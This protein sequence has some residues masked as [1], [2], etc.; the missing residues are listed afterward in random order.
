[1]M[2]LSYADVVI[3]GRP[4]SFTQSLPMTMALATP[5]PKRKVLQSFC[6]VNPAATEVM[7]FEDLKDWCC[8]GVTS[9]SLQGI[10]RYDYRRMPRVDGLDSQ[11]YSHLIKER[12]KSCIPKPTHRRDCLP[13]SMPSANG[14]QQV[15][16]EEMRQFRLEVWK[17]GKKEP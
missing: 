11:E 1:M 2:I 7:C 8:R 15:D 16:A 6:E 12:M 13:Y 17:Q 5:K 3:A 4:S 10:Q 9:F 14:M